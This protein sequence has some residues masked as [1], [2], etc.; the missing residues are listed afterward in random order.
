MLLE[1]TLSTAQTARR[2]GLSRERVVELN[3]LGRLPAIRT[4]LG[5]LF[6]P[7]VVERYAEKRAEDL[8]R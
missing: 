4:P 1:T 2:L 8:R 7:D 3:N 5:R 6:L